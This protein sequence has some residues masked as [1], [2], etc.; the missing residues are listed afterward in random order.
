MAKASLNMM[1]RTSAGDYVRDGIHMHALFCSI[2]FIDTFCFRNSV[3]TGWVTEENPAPI[4]ERLAE[5]FAPPLDIIDGAARCLDPIFDGH[6]TG[7]H[8]WG[9]F[10]KNYKEC[11]W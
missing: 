3:D 2:S 11:S 9:K 6:I 4:A 7:T 8:L 10:L 5:H 1:T